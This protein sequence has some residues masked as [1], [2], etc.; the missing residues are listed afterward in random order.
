MNTWSLA[1]I[2]NGDS[3]EPALRRGGLPVSAIAAKKALFTQAAANL[4]AMGTDPQ[5]PVYAFFVPGRIEVLGKHTDYAAGSSIVAALEQGFC[6]LAAARTDT[7][8]RFNADGYGPPAVFNLGPELAPLQ[9]HWSNYPMTIARRLARN[10]SG[11]RQ[12]MDAALA[13]DLPA[14]SGMS[15]SSALIVATY[16]ALARINR[17]DEDELYRSHIRDDLEL[18]A[19]LGTNENGQSF[20][21][22]A[23]DKGVGTFGGSEDHTAI[24]CSQSGTLGQFAYC[25]TR[26]ERRLPLPQDCVF[27][28][29]YSGVVAEKT[30]QAQAL[31][32]RAALLVSAL[33]EI[34]QQNTGRDE[35][36]LGAILASAP[37]A[38]QRLVNAIEHT[39]V[40]PFTV[41]ELQT[42][43]RHFQAENGEII[44]PAGDALAA[45]ELA[46][47]GRLVDRSQALTTDWLG[48]QVPETVA[49][50]RLARQ[51]GAHAASAFGAGFGGSVWA[52]VQK[53]QAEAFAQTWSV[54]YTA[55]FPHRAHAASFFLSQASPA[56]FAI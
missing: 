47:F 35:V 32:N 21:A 28:L 25:P 42:R 26:F 51:A 36:Y 16:L 54:A 33:V 38:A 23:G 44:G 46:T 34:W 43:L 45:G 48:N 24:L 15:S 3:L 1:A 55:A 40:A 56:A 30:G 49:L 7:T 17:L 31:Y 14:A 8:I 5:S 11:C 52:L 19:Y 12:G 6:L 2:A 29:G 18:A 27:V 13:S 53:E 20:G 41:A 39:P 4:K 22:L 37:D 50:A 9:G 10:F